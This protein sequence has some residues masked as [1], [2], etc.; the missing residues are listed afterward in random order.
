M[1]VLEQDFNSAA[2][3]AIAHLRGRE[4]ALEPLGWTGRRAEWIA[5]VCLHCGVFTRA[6][7]ARFMDAHPEQLRRGV[8]ADRAGLGRRGDR[9]R[10]SGGP[11]EFAASM[12]GAPYRALGAEDIC[13]RRDASPAVLMRRQ[14]APD[15][16]MEH[17]ICVG[18]PPKPRCRGDQ[19]GI[20]RAR[21]HVEGADAAR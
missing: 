13:H 8:Y 14:L 21:E 16:L 20:P 1:D 17:A 7:W 11:D 15:Y 5:L 10:H 19:A 12:P 9:A 6:Q 18:F 4:K 2:S 3:G